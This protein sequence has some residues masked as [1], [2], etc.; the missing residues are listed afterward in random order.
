MNRAIRFKPDPLDHALVDFHNEKGSFTPS[1]VGLILNESFTGCALVIK[2]EK[3]LNKDQEIKVQ[4]GRLEPLAAKVIWVQP[5][6]VNLI[7]C[8]LQ[9]LE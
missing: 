1:A 3:V 9:F 6:E 2:S 4:V 5:L 7:K 8:G